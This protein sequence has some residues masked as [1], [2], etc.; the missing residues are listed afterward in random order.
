MNAT[1][2]VGSERLVS[3]EG[4][5]IP[6]G[7]GFDD[8]AI[9]LTF[10]VGRDAAFSPTGAARSTDGG[11]TWQTV[12]SP[13]HRAT[14]CGQIN[15]GRAL[16]FDQDLWHVGGDQFLALA[17]ETHDSGAT[18]TGIREVPITIP[19]VICKPYHPRAKDD[20][21]YFAE[22]EVPAFY[23]RITQKHGAVIG[24]WINGRILRLADGALVMSCYAN[25]KG[26]LSRRAEHEYTYVA[27]RPDAGVAEEGVANMLTSSLLLR[28]DDDGQTWQY[29][30][31]IGKIEKNKPYDG[32]ILYSEGFN[33]TGLA[34]TS[35][36][37]LLALMRHGSYHLIWSNRSSDGGRTWQ[38]IEPLNHPGVFPG[39]ERMGNGALAAAWGRPGMTVAFS[40]DGTGHFWDVATE[41]MRDHEQSQKYPWL[42]PIADDT[43]L[44]FYDRRTWIAEKRDYGTHGIYCRPITLKL[45]SGN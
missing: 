26:N 12:T 21:D 37:D 2:S 34:E 18:F 41:L 23:D 32:G 39:L 45:D 16:Y 30:S 33:E 11:N 22:P 29:A 15:P 27:K 35:D 5:I 43:V 10:H 19:N 25:I 40:T 28:S 36:G 8:G 42:I 14:A 44:V 1:I 9:H 20:P 38:G 13:V 6:I 17:N 7:V 31:T 4:T 3:R 24:G